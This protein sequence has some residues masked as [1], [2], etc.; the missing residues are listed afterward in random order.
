M[1]IAFIVLVRICFALCLID[2]M[3]GYLNGELVGLDEK[4]TDFD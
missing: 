3:R 2:S 1:R 4:L